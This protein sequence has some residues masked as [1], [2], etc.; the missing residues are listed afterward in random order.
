[1]RAFVYDVIRRRT[2]PRVRQ[3]IKSRQWVMPLV[4]RLFGG[5]IYSRSYYEQVEEA[6]QASVLAIATWIRLTLRPIRVVDIGCGPGHLIEAL[7]RGGIDVLGLDYS[8]AAR[9]FVSKK[10]LPFETLDLTTRGVVPGSPWDLAVCCE[11]AEHLDA[12]HS[13][14]FVENLTSASNTVFLTAAE[15]GQG[16]LNHVNE[17]PNSYWIE[18]FDHR[19]FALDG[20]LTEKARA[21][22]AEGEVVHYLA[23]PMIFR[24]AEK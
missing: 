21:A 17:Q 4:A 18:K 24:R 20:N 7:H 12:R 22:F 5:D 6:E 3:F 14:T 8:A 9:G 16:G 13:D 19:G 11:V 1:L 2:T 23:K 10:G 15:V